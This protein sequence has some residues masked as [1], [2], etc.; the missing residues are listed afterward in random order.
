AIVVAVRRAL[1]PA[2][3]EALSSPASRAKVATLTPI[4]S[5]HAR[6]LA[7]AVAKRLP[8]CTAEAATTAVGLLGLA[9]VGYERVIAEQLP[10][11]DERAGREALRALAKI[12]THKAA[13]L[14]VDQL[15]NG[16]GWA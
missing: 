11:G 10:K 7:P 12:G 5:S 14:V 9:G 6:E 8:H 13:D 4:L 15:E 1:V 2:W 16:P 3:L